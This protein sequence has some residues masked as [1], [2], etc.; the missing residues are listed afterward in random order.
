MPFFPP[1]FSP[2]NGNGTDSFRKLS[3]QI[4]CI[5]FFGVT[6]IISITGNI[7]DV[8]EV[9]NISISTAMV[10]RSI[11]F[12][13]FFV[14]ILIYK[15]YVLLG[16]HFLYKFLNQL[17]SIITPKKRKDVVLSGYFII[18]W[19]ILIQRAFSHE[20][21]NI[22]TYVT[23]L[24]VLALCYD[25]LLEPGDSELKIF[26]RILITYLFILS[27]GIAF[28]S[29]YSVWKSKVGGYFTISGLVPFS[30]ANGYLNG[31]LRFIENGKMN[32]WGSR[33][34]LSVLFLSS[35][36]RLSHQNI[37]VAM[38]IQVAL[39]GLMEFFL[40]KPVFKYFGLTAAT[41][42]LIILKGF[43]SQF[44]HAF[45]TEPAG[46]LL[47]GIGTTFFI[48]ASI[49]KKKWLYHA[50]LFFLAMGLSA[51][52]GA[53]ISLPLLILYPLILFKN[54]KSKVQTVLIGL[55]IVIVALWI[56]KVQLKFF[57]AE[58]YSY[59]GSFAENL[60]GMVRGEK[61]WDC[62]YHEHPNLSELSNRASASQLIYQYAWQEFKKDPNPF[63]MTFYKQWEKAFFHPIL[64]LYAGLIEIAKLNWVQLFFIIGITWI[65][66]VSRGEQNRFG[67]IIPGILGVF[68]SVPFLYAAHAG[69]RIYAAT[70][71]FNALIPT[72]GIGILLSMIIGSN[73]KTNSN[74][75]SHSAFY[76]FSIF[77]FSLFIFGPIL[78]RLI[79]QTKNLP[80]DCS[81]DNG[82][83]KVLFFNAKGSHIRVSDHDVEKKKYDYVVTTETLKSDHA[84]TMMKCSDL[85]E[86]GVY[87]KTVFNMLTDGN[88]AYYLFSN[89]PIHP[90][91][92][93]VCVCGE[94][95][96]SRK[97][98]EK[99]LK[100][101]E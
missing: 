18:I 61:S 71:F 94:T 81:C 83:Q 19:I 68:I 93:Y 72:I 26:P 58:S 11:I 77:I 74:R 96:Y 25:L 91:N 99:V 43:I 22:N 75:Q 3:F 17:R 101:R 20:I 6:F 86:E 24:L 79:P 10:I 98:K 89:K 55:S 8:A 34:P 52:A 80:Q 13:I 9:F 85:I 33:R 49:D 35:L 84:F 44:Q 100:I 63:F 38:L 66:L 16:F 53:F 64:F 40:A 28:L 57:G 73:H 50:G 65:L 42:L 82:D 88:E 1:Q 23:E 46:F 70:I 47:G 31:A 90:Y 62:V 45:M 56:S 14:L 4:F 67:F 32:E 92:Q 30:D 36:L 78:N 87:F 29:I 54:Q 15:N 5:W 12:F 51:R 69:I 59:Q 21:I 95:V 48:I 97:N 76:L 39:I 2:I 7:N 41:I 27:I 60:Y 37:Q